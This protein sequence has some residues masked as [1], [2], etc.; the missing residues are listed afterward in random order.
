MVFR[1]ILLL[2][3]LICFAMSASDIRHQRINLQ[4]LGLVFLTAALL[5]AVWTQ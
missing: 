5:S 4:S 2:L 3:A 1:A